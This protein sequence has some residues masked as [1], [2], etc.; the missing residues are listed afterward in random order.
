MAFVITKWSLSEVGALQDSNYVY[1]KGR[2]GGL[3]SWLLS[4]VGVDPSVSIS[5]NSKTILF[6][7][8]SLA[9]FDKRV[10]PI[11]SVCSTY[12]GYS[13]PWLTAV[14][15][16]FC[17]GPFGLIIG[18]LYYFLN[19]TTSFGFVE[20]SGVTNGIQFKRSLIEGKNISEK[21]A[22]KAISIIQSL[23][24]QYNQG[25]SASANVDALTGLNHLYSQGIITAEEF[26]EK[27][28]K[29]LRYI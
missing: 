11:G 14:I 27:R 28:K 10:I 3:L 21:D 22:L 29:L 1:I 13:K 15:I 16:G 6:Q 2:E 24:E 23:L 8:G 19:K 4:L 20:N 25:T 9:G 12:Y 7:K 5:V 17:F 26:E 18:P